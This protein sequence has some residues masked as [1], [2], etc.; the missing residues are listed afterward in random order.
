M[1]TDILRPDGANPGG[2]R[3]I[4]FCPL[5][6][7]DTFPEVS[8]C[9]IKTAIVF[10][11]DYRFF[12]METIEN[13]LDYNCIEQE[14]DYGVLFK[15]SV[16]GTVR[17]DSLQLKQQ[18]NYLASINSFIVNVI[19][20]TGLS[21]IVGN[22]IEKCRFSFKKRNGEGMQALRSYQ[23]NFEGEFTLDPPVYNP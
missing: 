21:V 16:N 23:V 3:T 15:V 14:T 8:N 12:K 6:G 19:D 10:K 20:N 1:I 7:I 13:T 9:E 17:G 22:P 4:A 18:L 5:F 11:P 2:V